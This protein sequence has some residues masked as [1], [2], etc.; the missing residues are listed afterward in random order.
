MKQ[1]FAWTRETS[2][3]RR[4]FNHKRKKWTI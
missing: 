3:V 1:F 4:R 2:K